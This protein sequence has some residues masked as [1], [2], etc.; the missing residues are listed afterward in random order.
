[1]GSRSPRHGTGAA[2]SAPAHSHVHTPAQSMCAH[3]L[4]HCLHARVCAHS[5]VVHAHSPVH[6]LPAQLHTHTVCACTLT[7]APCARSPVLS[8]LCTL[9]L[10]A[11]SRVCILP[12][13]TCNCEQG[14]HGVTCKRAH[15][16]QMHV[17][18]YTPTC[19]C[20]HRHRHGLKQMCAETRVLLHTDRALC[21]VLVPHAA[22][23][24]RA[25]GTPVLPMHP[26]SHHLGTLSHH[27]GLSPG[28]LAAASMPRGRARWEDPLSAAPR[29]Q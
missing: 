5:H 13:P 26:T 10:T 3:S 23:P 18:V 11:C 20:V 15:R 28:L 7:H 19:M 24:L 2:A 16:A 25:P 22:C 27:T 21:L 29:S 9:T 14:P 1:M 17:P 12:R 4:M 6:C 8:G